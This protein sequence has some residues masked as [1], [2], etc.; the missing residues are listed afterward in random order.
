MVASKLYF[1]YSFSWK[2]KWRRCVRSKCGFVVLHSYCFF[3]I[4]LLSLEKPHYRTV[5]RLETL[6]LD[7][8]FFSLH[9]LSGLLVSQRLL[10]HV[11][12]KLVCQGHWC[13]LSFLTRTASTA[14]STLAAGYLCKHSMH[15]KMRCCFE[16]N[17]L[18]REFRWCCCFVWIHT[19]FQHPMTRIYICNRILMLTLQ[20]CILFLTVGS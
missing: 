15:F 16:K 1:H 9:H 8:V 2:K 19:W 3:F 17:K 13:H 7:A 12:M 6:L 11:K 10:F 5:S 14:V 20:V 18:Q 4:W